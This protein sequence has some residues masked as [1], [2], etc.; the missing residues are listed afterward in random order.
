MAEQK[1]LSVQNLRACFFTPEGVVK[2][3]NGVSFNIPPGKTLGVLG[4][5][6]CGKSVTAMS[7][8]RL[9]PDPPGKI[10]EGVV[11]FKGRDLLSLSQAEIRKIRGNE[12]GMI[13]QE[14]MTS[15]NPVYTIGNQI[16]EALVI[17]RGLNYNDAMDVAIEQLKLVGIPAPEK[18]V[19]EYP[20]QL[21]GGMRQRAMIAMAI[22]CRPSLLIADEPTTALDVTI[23]AQILDLML[24][25]Q[26]TLGMAF[27]MITH[28]LGVIVEV[29]DNI[30]V[31]YAGQIVE[32]IPVST[33]FS[34]AK[35][36]Y[37]KGLLASNPVM[38]KKFK[39]GKK[40]LNEIVGSVPSLICLP[41]GCLFKDRCPIAFSKC[42]RRP[43]L[44][45]IDKD[46]QVRCWKAED[47]AVAVNEV[48]T[49][50]AYNPGVQSRGRIAY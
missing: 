49:E 39:T 50:S 2:A 36:P 38:G 22:S 17:H 46:H 45:T 16:S 42:K 29:S 37:T 18:R 44:F 4:E 10:M 9:I 35:H 11:L 47:E 23:Q 31:M 48:P 43:P 28:D 3:V 5:S 14:P 13:F 33:L 20:H 1:L 41:S 24:E 8:L 21:S 15:L 25:L 26:E 34:G 40:R 27:M 6:G 30:V 32:S 12:I 7:I 19:R